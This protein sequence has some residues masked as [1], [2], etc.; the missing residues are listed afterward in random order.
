MWRQAAG[1]PS[2]QIFEISSPNGANLLSGALERTVI[3]P[4]IPV[5]MLEMAIDEIIDVIAV[6]HRLMTATGTML[7]PAGF[8][9]RG[10]GVR[11]AGAHRDD[12][13]VD[14]IAM[15]VVQMSVMQVVDMTVMADGDVAA[16]GA[17]LVRMVGVRWVAAAGHLL[18]PRCWPRPR[19]S[20]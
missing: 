4:V 3:V 15:H 14:V 7:V 8:V 2:S 11:I 18:S 19:P 17:V 1:R 5:W 9:L 20:A 6:R 16:T 10:A 12:M 13:L